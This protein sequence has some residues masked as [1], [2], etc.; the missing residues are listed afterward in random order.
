ML[1]RDLVKYIR[2]GAKSKYEKSSSCE[3]CG[4]NEQLEFHHYYGLTEL[5]EK[6]LKARGLK[7][8]SSDEIIAVRDEFILEHQ[9][10][11]YEATATLCKPHHDK[12]HSVYGKRP[13]LATAEKQRRWVK[14]NAE[15]VTGK[16]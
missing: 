7:I 4:T 15:M 3:I 11:L 5:L 6:W 10:E 13:R 9:H 16:T 12:L 2:D 1:K 14:R 8:T